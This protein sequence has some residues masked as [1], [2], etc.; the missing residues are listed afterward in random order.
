M[1]WVCMAY[2]YM[3]WG[4]HGI[5]THCEGVHGT[6]VRC[7]CHGCALCVVTYGI[8]VQGVCMVCVVVYGIGVHGV[9][10]H[11]VDVHGAGIHGIYVH[12]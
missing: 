11:G 3:E 10:E 7:L 5:H 1:V 8:G 12:L 4:V 6:G 9:V 2:V